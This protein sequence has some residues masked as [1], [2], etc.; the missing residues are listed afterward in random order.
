MADGFVDDG[1]GRVT[2]LRASST[3][4]PLG[5]ISVAVVA[6]DESGVRERPWRYYDAYGLIFV[7]GG[8]GWY[9]DVSGHQEPVGAGQVITVLPGY[10]HWYGPSPAPRWDELFVVFDGPLFDGLRGAGVLDERRPVRRPEPFAEWVA[11]VTDAVRPAPGAQPVDPRVELLRF[12]TLLGE[13]AATDY[14]AADAGGE[15]GAVRRACRLLEADLDRPMALPAVAEQVGLPYSTF[16]HR[17]ARETG[18]SPSRY[19]EARR[20]QAACDLLRSTT[21]THRQI[22]RALGYAD[23][24]HFSKR[25]RQQVGYPPRA[26]RD[27]RAHDD[28]HAGSNQPTLAP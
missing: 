25:F 19:R 4:T 28:G 17:F 6:P 1:E 5:R 2:V 26:Y 15:E 16:R 20:I 27:G 23:E 12:A 9:R 21:M 11:R 24:F 7:T 14:D 18:Q 3:T 8:R 10:G 22:A 13:L